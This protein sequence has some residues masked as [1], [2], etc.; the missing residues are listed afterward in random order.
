MNKQVT[1]LALVLMASSGQASADGAADWVREH[2]Q[3]DGSP[4]RSCASCHGNDLTQPSQH[5]TTRKPIAPLAPSVNS[6]RLTDPSKVE[7]WLRRNCRWTL[8]RLC[9]QAEKDGFIAY[10]R[11]Q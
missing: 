6:E 2:P 8:G 11:S 1:G 4:A 5:A 7:K 3:P 10:I 9:T